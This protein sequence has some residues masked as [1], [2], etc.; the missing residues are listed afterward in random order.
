MDEI[1]RIA[2]DNHVDF[3]LLGGDLFHD[4][5]PSRFTLY[6]TMEIFRKRWVVCI[7]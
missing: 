5:N 4:N 2:E 1:M 7:V 6:K 3:V